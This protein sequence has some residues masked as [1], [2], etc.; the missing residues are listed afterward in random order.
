M[1]SGPYVNRACWSGV[2]H[3]SVAKKQQPGGIVP[4][5]GKRLA[6]ARKKIG[7]TQTELATRAGIRQEAL[8]R[9]ENGGR[10]LEAP[11][12]AAVLRAAAEAGVSV[13]DYVLRGL[14]GPVREAPIAIAQ[15]PALRGALIELGRQLAEQE[16]IAE[17]PPSE[18]K[19][20]THK[21][22]KPSS[23]SR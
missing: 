21:S 19:I 16:G 18:P 14:G 22:R 11:L 8:S 12:F 7:L 5:I 3:R 1:S 15:D 9:F 6:E 20:P 4:E 13:D 23:S 17:G 10:G 2:Y